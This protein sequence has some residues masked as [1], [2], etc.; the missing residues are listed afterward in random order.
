VTS[1]A[2]VPPVTVSFCLSSLSV[3]FSD[4]TVGSDVSFL[5]STDASVVPG[6]TAAAAATHRRQITASVLADHKQNAFIS[7]DHINVPVSLDR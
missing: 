2:T 1:S 6:S 5:M 3:T 7:F 4:L